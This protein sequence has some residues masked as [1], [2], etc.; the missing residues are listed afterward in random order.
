MKAE[1]SESILYLREEHLYDNE[2]D[3]LD[4]EDIIFRRRSIDIDSSNRKSELEKYLE[5]PLVI[6]KVSLIIYI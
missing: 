6:K 1:S 2:T 5:E 4:N 3:D